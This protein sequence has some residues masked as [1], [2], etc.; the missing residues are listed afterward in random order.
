MT[1]IREQVVTDQRP[2]TPARGRFYVSD[3]VKSM[4]PLLVA[5]I[6]LGIYSTTHSHFFLTRQNMENLGEQ[7]SILGVLSVG[8]TFL[9]VAGYLDLSVG[10]L[11]SL[12][13]VIGA[14]MAVA[15]TSEAWIVVVAIAV[16]VGAGFLTGS[17]VGVVR[18]APFILTLGLMSVFASVALVLSN[19]QPVP[20]NEYVFA[21]LGLGKWLGVPASVVVLAAAVIAGILVLR[22]TK[23]GRNA[24]AVGSNPQAAFLSGI[25]IIRVT[26]GLYILSGALVGLGGI[27]LL[28]RLGAGDPNAGIG[29]E[30]QAVAAV[31]LGGAALSGGR[32]SVIGSLLGVILLGEIANSLT[33]LGVAVFYQQ[34]VYGG[35]LIV[36]VVANGLRDPARPRL[37]GERWL[38]REAADL[39]RSVRAR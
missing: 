11:T 18:V 27:I 29:L 20:V 16:G 30:L 31:V 37:S 39:V 7:I 34:M 6:G 8:M 33:I 25:S 12:I 26:V 13:S 17:V 3:S 14:K 23:L 36:A 38:K 15:G 9:M 10:A 2:V 4:I 32:G 35:V 1:E 19:G 28:G 24:F 5:I 21:S 22:Y